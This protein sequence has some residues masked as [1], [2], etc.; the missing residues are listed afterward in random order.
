[1]EN[2]STCYDDNIFFAEESNEEETAFSNKAMWKM[3]VVDDE[4]EVHYITQFSLGDYQY[5]N[6]GL[7]IFNAYSAAEAREILQQHDDIAIILLDVVMETDDAGLQLV[8]YIREK[9][10]NHLVRIVLRTGQPGQAP[11]KEVIVKYDI[12][13]YKNKTQLTDIKL[14]TLVTSNLRNYIDLTT[15]ESYRLNL[16]QKV[17]ERTEELTKKNQ[18]LLELNQ[19][20][21][22]LNQEKNEFLHIAAHDLKNPLFAIQSLANLIYMD[23]SRLKTERIIDFGRTI[24][25]SATE[26]FNLIKRLMDVNAIESG[27]MQFNLE[28]FNLLE[29][30]K[31]AING[32]QERAKLKNIFLHIHLPQDNDNYYIFADKHA[33]NEVIHNLVS[34][35]IKY[36]FSGKKVSLIVSEREQQACIE[37]KDEGP[38]LSADDQNNLFRKFGRLTPRPT[39]NESSSGLGLFIVK[40]LVTAMEGKIWCESELNVGTSFFV[41]FPLANEMPRDT[42]RE[43]Y[44]TTPMSRAEL[45]QRSFQSLRETESRLVQFLDAM[46]VGVAVVDH[47]GKL[48]YLNQKAQDLLQ[49]GIVPDTTHENFSQT[50]QL[51]HAGSETLYC[52]SHSPLTQAL[53]DGVSSS[54][55][56]VEIHHGDVSIPLEIWATPIYDEKQKISYAIAVFQDIAKRKKSEIE[57]DKFTSELVQLK[58]SYERF[59]PREFLNLLDKQNMIDVQL[60]D[61]VEKEMTVMFSDIR[62]FTSL[63][64]DMEPQEIFDFI[65]NYLGQMEPIILKHNGFIDKYIGDAIMALFPTTVDDAVRGSISM[66]QT[67]NQY[68]NLLQRAG[69]PAIQ[70]GIG[71]N[72]GPLILG[73]VGGQNR[74]D[75][76][77]ISDAV[78]TSARIEDLTKLYGSPLLITAQS[79]IKLKNI[80]EYHIRV[81][82]NVMVKGKTNTVIVYEVFDAD[83]PAMIELKLQTLRDFEQGFMC[84][85]NGNFDEAQYFF[86][87]VN[88]IN[89]KDQA[90]LVYLERCQEKPKKKTK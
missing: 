9:L 73:T 27:K 14:F 19:A 23:G 50:Y 62:G 48:Y 33:F 36:S 40:N 85:H 6:S 58:K 70:I 82:D 56:D 67:L 45:L 44:I 88:A 55:D 28:V 26:M 76:T 34:N 61:Q 71:L 54:V 15:I 86:E 83:A 80:M 11:E 64:E 78:N 22:H 89:P 75:G 29:T 69:Y 37:I 77:V 84:Y 13:D 25:N 60:G 74:M 39:A 81:I 49:K 46:P 32:Y 79:Y 1:M 47:K 38:G 2:N 30:L 4:E 42:V 20:L 90:T 51:Y 5:Q 7:H 59:V 17:I 12:N 10:Q 68:N 72:T 31:S 21:R 18:E 8:K 63:S 43:L 57:R 41:Q 52:A 24:E 35:A 66:L 3:L 87:K 53:L 65:N 16:E